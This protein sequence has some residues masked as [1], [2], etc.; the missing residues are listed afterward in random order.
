VWIFRNERLSWAPS[1]PKSTGAP[2]FAFFAKGGIPQASPQTCRV[3][4]DSPREPKQLSSRP[5]R[6]R[7]SY[8]A[9]LARTTCAALRRERAVC[10]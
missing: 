7:I 5:K 8:F 2:S 6:T 9:L 3:S 1:P 4:H 10:N